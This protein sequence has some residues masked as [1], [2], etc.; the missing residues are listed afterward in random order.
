[1]SQLDFAAWT[2]TIGATGLDARP[3]PQSGRLIEW[4]TQVVRDP[5]YSLVSSTKAKVSEGGF[6]LVR[7]DLGLDLN[8]FIIATKT[9]AEVLGTLR[10]NTV[11]MIEGRSAGYWRNLEGCTKGHLSAGAILDLAAN[12]EVEVHA[13]RVDTETANAGATM[14]SRGFEGQFSLWRL[15]SSWRTMQAWLVGADGADSTTS[16]QALV[17][18]SA[19]LASG[20]STSGNGFQFDPSAAGPSYE[21]NSHVFLVAVTIDGLAS[22]ATAMAQLQVDVKFDDGAGTMLELARVTS[23]AEGPGGCTRAVCGWVGL[24]EGLPDGALE[25]IEVHYRHLNT[26]GFS[27]VNPKANKC[28]LQVVAIPRAEI[29]YVNV[30]K[31]VGGQAADVDVAVTFDDTVHEDAPFDHNPTGDPSQIRGKALGSWALVMASAYTSPLGGTRTTVRLNHRL[32]LQDGGVS[33]QQ[34]GGMALN[35]GSSG[36]IHAGMNAHAIVKLGAE[37]DLSAFHDQTGT[38]T[39]AVVDFAGR[40]A[41]VT[42]ELCKLQAIRLRALGQTPGPVLCQ[43]AV[44]S[45][46]RTVQLKPTAGQVVVSPPLVTRSITLKPSAVLLGLTSPA[47]ARLIDLTPSPALLG[48][49]APAIARLV[50]LTPE[51]AS[52]PLI[53]P[54]VAR[55]LDLTPSPAEVAVVAPDVSRLGAQT[56]TAVHVAIAVPAIA[57]LVTLT[58]TPAEIQLLAPGVERLVVLVPD[59][60]EIGIVSPA[61]ARLVT[62]TPT[63]VE[64]LVLVPS[65][66]LGTIVVVELALELVRTAVLP[67]GLGLS[68]DLASALERAVVAQAA[69]VR[70]RVLG[71]NLPTSA[72]LALLLAMAAEAPLQASTGL[73][74]PAEGGLAAL[75]A[76][77]VNRAARAY[78]AL[79]RESQVEADFARVLA[80]VVRLE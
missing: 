76:A 31:D 49:V 18:D 27:H 8:T 52:I 3:I 50:T 45:V 12:D 78:A 21:A 51:P 14:I 75:L 61:V 67:A 7:Y 11:E 66:I 79:V 43:V 33:L 29:E 57:R 70:S 19:I 10:L 54:N 25:K 40:T 36:C 2:A 9:R 48:I 59:G 17:F 74:V 62:L 68:A 58:P 28:S 35:R 15:K 20:W 72:E 38:A 34:G 65:P 53:V 73:A 4:E 71:V 30:G 80:R 77:S 44:P 47:V 1:M 42:G 63:P 32:E 56:P 16:P 5:N 55:L 60:V 13:K 22:S 39:D 26:G 41:G 69:L 46:I 24:V 37:K 23:F 64:I 6:Y